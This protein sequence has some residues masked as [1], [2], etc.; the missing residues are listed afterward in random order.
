M[1]ELVAELGSAFL[2][3]ETGLQ[4]R[5]EGHASY[6]KSWLKVLKHDKRAIITAASKA[7]Q[8]ARLI[9]DGE[10]V[11]MRATTA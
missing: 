9:L 7:R 10:P 8:A 6:I 2:S 1:E 5:I 4:G 3:A 11:A